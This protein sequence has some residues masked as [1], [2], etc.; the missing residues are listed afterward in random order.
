VQS[1]A[2]DAPPGRGGV[3]T[4]RDVY[5]FDPLPDRLVENRDRVLGV[6]ANLWTE[7][8]R[9]EQR[10]GYMI[11]PRAAAL[12]EVAWSTPDRRDFE[13]FSARLARHLPRLDELGLPF[14][15]EPQALTGTPLSAPSNPLRR[16]DRQ[17]ELCQAAIELIL[18]DDAPLQG[19]REAYRLD[20]MKRCWLW[21]DAPLGDAAGVRASVGQLPFNFEIGDLLDDVEVLVPEDGRPVMTVRQGGCEGPLLAALDLAPALD[22]PAATIL[23]VTPLAKGASRPA[24]ADLCIQFQHSTLD[25]FWA[26]DWVELVSEP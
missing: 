21:R 15:R 8:V 5:A 10:A 12:A 24:Q 25:P 3:I 16:E 18:E 11:W 6:Q 4:V 9:T 26:L 20:I 13:D 7:H 23:P 1:E 2:P 22:N 14:A 19:P 17:L